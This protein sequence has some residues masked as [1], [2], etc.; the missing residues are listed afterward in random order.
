MGEEDP[1]ISVEIP[2]SLARV[3]TDDPYRWKY[4][5]KEELLDAIERAIEENDA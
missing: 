5:D 3:L 1:L 2:L 4:K